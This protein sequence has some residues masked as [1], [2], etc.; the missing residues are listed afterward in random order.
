[1]NSKRQVKTKNRH[2]LKDALSLESLRTIA[3]INTTEEAN[4]GSLPG[5]LR[6][7]KNSSTVVGLCGKGFAGSW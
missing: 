1:M 3:L 4:R 5:G 2:F 6:Q 7:Q